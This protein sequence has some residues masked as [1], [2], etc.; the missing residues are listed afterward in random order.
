MDKAGIGQSCILEVQLGQ[1]WKVRQVH[2]TRIADLGIAEEQFVQSCESAD[3]Y[4]A[5]VGHT[6]VVEHQAFELCEYRKVRNAVIGDVGALEGNHPHCEERLNTLEPF[7]RQMV[8]WGTRPD[9]GDMRK[10][11][12]KV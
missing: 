3:M 10:S 5:G 12:K 11:R 2:K 6:G 8:S 9:T 7:V 1:L 4:Q